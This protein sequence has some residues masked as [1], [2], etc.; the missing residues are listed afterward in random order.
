MS[1]I[2]VIMFNSDE[3]IVWAVTVH[4]PLKWHKGGKEG[5][6]QEIDINSPTYV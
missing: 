6:P 3:I 2:V 4:R 1:G 5:V